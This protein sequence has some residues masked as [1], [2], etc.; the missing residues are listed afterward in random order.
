MAVN[1]FK[2][3]W[4][5]MRIT[6]V[7]TGGF[8]SNKNCSIARELL[9][10]LSF[11][12]NSIQLTVRPEII[13]ERDTDSNFR[14]CKLLKLTLSRSIFNWFNFYEY[15]SIAQLILNKKSY[16]SKLIRSS[17]RPPIC[18]RRQK[19]APTFR[20]FSSIYGRTLRPITTDPKQNS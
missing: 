9:Y 17:V 3:Q 14:E 10:F 12:F 16:K 4:L 2:V 19:M 1:S 6:G 20:H 15:C 8:Y 18:I 7:F 13:A 11:G 5:Q